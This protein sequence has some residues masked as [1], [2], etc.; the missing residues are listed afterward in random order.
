MRDK[1]VRRRRATA[2]GLIVLSLLLLTAYFGEGSGGGLHS[3]QRGALAVLGPIEEGATRALKPVRDLFGWVGD[4]FDAKEERDK[5]LRANA[6]LE[7]EIAEL[8]RAAIDNEELKAIL[9]INSELGFDEDDVVQAL[10]VGR[11]PNLFH[12]QINIDKGSSAGLELGQAV[13]NGEGLVGRVTS[14]SRGYSQVTL[15]T[16]DTFAAGVQVGPKGVDAV[17]RAS[18]NRP[19]ELE[20]TL[21]NPDRVSEGD[22]VTTQGTILAEQP[23]YYPRGILIGKVTDIEFGDGNFDTVVRVKPSPDLANLDRVEV[24]TASPEPQAVASAE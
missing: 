5:L 4:T 22:R 8:E 15:V 17:A 14:V 13:L 12:R 9:N 1:Q 16:D 21:F 23:S 2:L 7:R 19:G 10:V 6:D 3:V 11:A 20:L 24:V 18:Q